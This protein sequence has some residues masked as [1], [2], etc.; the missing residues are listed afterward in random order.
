MGFS[1]DVL[2][3]GAIAFLRQGEM[4]HLSCNYRQILKEVSRTLNRGIYKFMVV[5]TDTRV[6]RDFLYLHGLKRRVCVK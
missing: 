3:W 2:E 1:M 4:A 5:T 6:L